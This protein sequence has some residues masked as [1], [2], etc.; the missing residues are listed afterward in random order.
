[1]QYSV[2]MDLWDKRAEVKA[3]VQQL[4]RSFLTP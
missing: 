1:V 4:V 2:S 3:A